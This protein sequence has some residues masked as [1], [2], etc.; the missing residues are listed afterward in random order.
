M[1]HEKEKCQIDITEYHVELAARAWMNWQF[2]DRKWDDA[3][4]EIKKV[5]IEGAYNALVAAFCK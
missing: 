4:P 5:F 2:P 3:V 1:H